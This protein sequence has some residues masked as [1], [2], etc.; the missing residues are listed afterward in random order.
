MLRSF[1]LYDGALGGIQ[2]GMF[3]YD[4]ITRQFAMRI[5]KDIQPEKLPLSLEGF[6]L[7]GKHEMSHEDTLRWIKGRICQPGRHNIREILRSNGLEEYDEFSLLMV[8]KAKCDKDELYLV[9]MSSQ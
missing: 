8:T 1:A 6:A 3:T 2:V 5:F 9:E 7:K 4:P